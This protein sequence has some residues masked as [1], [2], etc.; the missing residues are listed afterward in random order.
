MKY[1]D[2]QRIRK[3]LE[4]SE[5]LSSYIAEKQI[6]REDL[7]KEFSLQWLVT[8]PLY[9]IGEH[10]YYLSSDYKKQHNN[11]P[12]AMISGLRHRLVHN[13]DGTNWT[14]IA[15]VVFNEL[16]ELIRQLK[17]IDDSCGQKKEKS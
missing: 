13:Y 1:S 7:I 17:S 6:S 9:N 12:W 11:I 2:E 5:Q 14:I 4:Y 15:D 10:A 16:P 8:T 3:I